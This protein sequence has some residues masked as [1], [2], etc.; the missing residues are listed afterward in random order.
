VRDL[1]AAERDESSGAPRAATPPTPAVALRGTAKRYGPLEALRA[2]SLVLRAGERVAVVGPSGAGKSTLLR[3]VNTSLAP[4][5]GSVEVLGVDVCRLSPRSLRALRA[6]IGTVYQQLHLVPQA[7]VMQNVVAGRLGRMS[8]PRALLALLS[9][10]E[11]E[12]VRAVLAQVGIA[13]KL[14]ERVDRLSGGEQ[15]RVAI[16]RALYQDPELLVADEPFASVDPARA[17]E[18]AALLARSSAGRTLVVTTHRLE[19]LLPHIDRVVGLR[20]GAVTFDRPPA[21]LTL[22]DLAGLYAATRGA[23]AVRSPRTNGRPSPA[24]RESAGLLAIGA[25]NTPGE[26]VI[27]RTVR[28]FVRSYPGVRL[29]V[30]VKDT[31]EITADLLAGRIDL[32]FVG[33]RSPHPELEYEDVAEDEIVLVTAPGLEGLPE[34]PVPAAL[35][36]RLP[37]VEREAGSGTRAV[38]EEHLANLG[39]PLDP[40]AVQLEVSSLVGLKAAVLSGIGVAFASRLAVADELEEGHLRAL[41]IDGVKIPRRLFAAWRRGVRPSPAAARVLELA[42]AEVAARLRGA[43]R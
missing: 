29:G 34:E 32:A 41:R 40:A 8:V 20:A 37:R 43:A 7:S 17:E 18:I 4:S 12:R 11:A 33:A 35:A 15:Q 9:R 10:D 24:P 1:P 38:V 39:A 36:A 27:P 19:P 5:A 23:P 26:F 25:S 42:R 21:A 2:V 3:L 28:A 13:E 22:D 31:A 14:F 30:A 6:R 16:A